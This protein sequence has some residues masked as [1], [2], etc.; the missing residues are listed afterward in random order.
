MWTEYAVIILYSLVPYSL[1][2][3]W[4]CWHNDNCG[5]S[6]YVFIWIHLGQ[7]W[8]IQ[9][10]KDIPHGQIIMSHTWCLSLFVKFVH[11]VDFKFWQMHLFFILTWCW[12]CRYLYNLHIGGIC[13]RPV[14]QILQCAIPISHY[15]PFCNKNVHMPDLWD[16]SI[17]DI[18]FQLKLF[19]CNEIFFM[20]IYFLP[21]S[22]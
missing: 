19:K 5:F 3:S 1:H 6:L 9:Q 14:S 7:Y 11:Q 21:R 4:H 10:L 20:G 12:N 18:L 22:P 2:Q 16:G 8:L 15:V 13:N 17:K